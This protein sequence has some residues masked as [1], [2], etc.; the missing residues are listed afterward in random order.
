M[1][2]RPYRTR[3][4]R[5]AVYRPMNRRRVIIVMTVAVFFVLAVPLTAIF[6]G[7]P[8]WPVIFWF[9]VSHVFFCILIATT[10]PFLG[11]YSEPYTDPLPPEML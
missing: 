11:P 1:S 4:A 7:L 3:A 10:K 8:P 5:K 6:G 9:T 2:I